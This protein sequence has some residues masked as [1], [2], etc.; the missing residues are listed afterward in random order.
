MIGNVNVNRC[1]KLE[2]HVRISLLVL[3]QSPIKI[4]EIFLIADGK[5]KE[6][7]RK[8]NV[9]FQNQKNREKS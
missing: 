8:A 6:L 3:E 4:I 1:K 9:Q 2:Y 5:N 7:K